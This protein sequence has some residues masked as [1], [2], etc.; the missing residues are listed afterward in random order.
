MMP[1]RP[2]RPDAVHRRAVR[3]V[4]G[5]RPPES[6]CVRHLCRAGRPAPEYETSRWRRLR[7]RKLVCLADEAL[8][9]RSTLQRR[10]LQLEYEAAC[11]A[12]LACSS[13]CRGWGVSVGR[14]GLD[15]R[16]FLAR[17]RPRRT[18]AGQKAEA[19]KILRERGC[20]CGCAM[21]VAE[22]RFDDPNCMYSTGVAQMIVEQIRKGKTEAEAIAAADAS[23]FA[24]APERKLLEDAISIPIDGAPFTGPEKA[25]VTL[26]EFSDFQ[27]PYCAQATPRI[28]DLLKLVIPP[29]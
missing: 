22:C 12:L 28:E 21:K 20:G 13:A 19:L 6:G 5:A 8:K 29:T 15:F 16:D 23:Q 9:S 18:E 25:R 24:H 26:V 7:K 1:K 2:G 10:H 17:C 11:L 4:R 3:R 14:P 27:C